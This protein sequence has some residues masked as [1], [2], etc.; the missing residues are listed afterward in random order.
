MPSWKKIITSGSSAALSSLTVTNSVTAESFT[1][2]LQGSASY[3]LTASYALNGGGSGTGS[4]IT[5]SFA[6]TTSF[7][8]SHNLGTRT[9]VITVFDSNYNQII[10]TNI[11][12]V[13]VSSA[14]ITFSR[15]ESGFAIGSTGGTPGNAISSSFALTASYALNSSG[16]TNVQSIANALIFG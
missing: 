15:L 12:L 2:S 9:P 11:E 14:L 1:G 7:T 6:N 13:N 8:F 4:T 5:G 3:A 10:P 16:I